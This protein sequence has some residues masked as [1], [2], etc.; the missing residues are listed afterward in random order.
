[1]T[2]P[3]PAPSSQYR[4]LRQAIRPAETEWGIIQPTLSGNAIA[5]P[6]PDTTGWRDATPVETIGN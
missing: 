5:E 1:M 3:V 2:G 6:L 4:A